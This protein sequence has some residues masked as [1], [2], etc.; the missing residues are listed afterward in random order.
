MKKKLQLPNNI[1][2]VEPVEWRQLKWLQG[3]LKSA[4]PES[5]GKLVASIKKHG[6]IRPFKVWRGYILDGHLL[7]K[8]LEQVEAD[9]TAIPTKLLAEFVR[10]RNLKHAKELVLVY[11]SI[12]HKV[13]EDQLKL[14]LTEADLKL[15]NLEQFIDIPDM[16]LELSELNDNREKVEFTSNKHFRVVITCK[17]KQ[18][19]TKLY[20]RLKKEGFECTMK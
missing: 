7:Q 13:D 17:G 6:F 16:H 11:S 3:D 14:Y 20:M 4:T 15:S 5:L 1:E 18:Q 9:G 19:Q 10:C 12:Y 8:A 2:K